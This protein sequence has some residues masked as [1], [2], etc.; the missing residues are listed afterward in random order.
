MQDEL[1]SVIMPAYNSEKYI[2]DSIISVLMQTYKNW[3]LIIIDDGSK[4]ATKN[5]IQRFQDKR[6]IYIYQKN[7]GVA[8][9]RNN[10]IS[11][12]NGRYIAFL[13]SD[14]LWLSNKLELQLNYMQNHNYG[15]TYTWYRQFHIEP[16]EVHKVVKTKQ[17]VDYLELLKGN[18][19]G[20]LTVMI[21]RH[22]I[23]NIFMPSSHHED[24]VT[25]LNIL[26]NG[27][28]AHALAIDLA[29]YRKTNNSLTGNKFKS[30]LWTWKVYRVTQKFSIIKSLY[31]LS[32]YLIQ[33][34]K[35]HVN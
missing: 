1:I 24:Y 32:Y 5:V 14:D 8:S 10:G 31:Y 22:Y 3:E 30:L 25:W 21:D 2:A 13:D 6:I 16:D 15:F 19:I 7:E 20:C 35:K 26:R 11:K 33:G 34:I 12:A 18:D 17:S 23:K 28:K 29:R 27:Y 4:D 9:A